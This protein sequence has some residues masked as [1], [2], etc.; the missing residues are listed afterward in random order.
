MTGAFLPTCPGCGNVCGRTALRCQGC[1][2]P[3]Y[4]WEMTAR[5]LSRARVAPSMEDWWRSQFS[6][7]ELRSLGADL[8]NN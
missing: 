2:K 6:D 4:G 5:E 1:G 7:D 8:F 3:L